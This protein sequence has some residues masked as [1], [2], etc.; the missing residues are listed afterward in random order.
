M[1]LLNKGLY[2]SFFSYNNLGDK[3]R[4]L[5]IILCLFFPL[6]VKGIS[7]SSYIV[8]DMDSGRVL[9][10]KNIEKES[11]IASTTKILTAI[12][13][14]NYGDLN[15][16][17][18]VNQD[19]LKA[20]GSGIYI[21]VGEELLLDDLLY[22]LMLRSGNDAALAIASHVGGSVENFVYLMNEE[23]TL[24]GMK[25]SHFLNPSGLEENDGTGNTS[26]VYDMAILTRYAMQN[27]HYRRITGTK[28]I[29]V[30]SNLKTYRWF[31][32]NK[33]LLNYKY[34]TGGKTGY[35][36]KAHRTL[37]TT[38]SKDGMNLIV[39][40]FNDGNDFSDH[41]ELYDK[42]FE[43]YERVKVLDKNDDYGDEFVLKNDFYLVKNDDDK[44]DTKVTKYKLDGA[45]NGSIV[46]KVEVI[47]NDEIIG[48]RN[49]YYEKKSVSDN[50]SF[51]SKLW[52]FIMRW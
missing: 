48:S 30:K 23:A 34:C 52:D 41:Q 13:A 28:D 25:N 50:K 40:T 17:V 42:Y 18:K 1:K 2:K 5:V 10:G 11:L 38:A 24:I 27:E 20:Y 35:T 3:M 31:N 46:G 39:V 33:L 32:K 8:M 36:Q 37:V 14:I 44:V 9:E 4:I 51:L 45:V 7:A 15:D 22:G 6:C 12:T 19:I 26:T 21:Q 29:V 49:L 47:L 43:N 16:V